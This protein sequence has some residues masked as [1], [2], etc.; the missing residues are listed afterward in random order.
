MPERSQGEAGAPHEVVLFFN[1]PCLHS[2][3]T[4]QLAFVTPGRHNC[5]ERKPKYSQVKYWL[6]LKLRPN[7]QQRAPKARA[8]HL[9][10]LVFFTG[11]AAR[12]VAVVWWLTL[13]GRRVHTVLCPH[14]HQHAALPGKAGALLSLSAEMQDGNR[15]TRD[16]HLS[17]TFLFSPELHFKSL[18][19]HFCHIVHF[20]GHFVTGI[21]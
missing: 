11:F 14:W 9:V 8:F 19:L 21:W 18:C 20:W 13:A 4:P 16:N 12:V 10:I 6:Y 3:V 2:W 7:A 17:E 15:H 1:R 5:G